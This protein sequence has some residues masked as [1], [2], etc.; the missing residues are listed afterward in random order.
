MTTGLVANARLLDSDGLTDITI[1]DGRITRLAPASGELSGAT[2]G[3]IDAAGG[4]VC[5]SFVDAH[6]HPDKA[7]TFPRLGPVGTTSMEDSMARGAAI[8]S[9]FTHDDV[10]QRATQ[11]IEVA[12]G[13]GV[14]AVRAQ[15]DVDSSV[16]LIGFEALL[17]VRAAYHS[18]IDI[19][20]V[21][22]PQEGIVR[23]P[24]AV[25]LL[26]KALEMG[27]DLIGGGPENE[28]DPTAYAPHLD[29]IF[30]LA[31]D[32]DVDVDLHADMTEVPSRRA[33]ELI[34]RETIARRWQGRVNVVHCCA[35]AAYPDDLAAD[36]IGLVAEAG[37]QIC[38]CP[39]GNLQLVGEGVTPRGR[40][41]SR[42]KELLTAGVNVAAGTDNLHDMWFRFGNLDPVET[43]LITCLSGALRTDA[44]VREGFAMV[45]TRAARYLRLEDYGLYQGAKADLVVFSPERLEDVIRGVPG[46]RRILKAGSLVASRETNVWVTPR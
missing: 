43:C 23:D 39:V 38:I 29:A 25:V 20:L 2:D 46:T 6:F 15:V 26:Q 33:L 27:A 22:F 35:L 24:G 5:P 21:A 44:E 12:I 28:G 8:K 4:L 10:V 34:A 9:A 41:A 3:I 1:S 18:L 13:N 7:L 30:G 40:G 42:P 36:V 45:T 11:A 16:G 31:R 17:E 19:Q 32:F 14:G 37:I